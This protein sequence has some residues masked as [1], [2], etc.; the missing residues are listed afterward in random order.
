MIKV[1]IIDDHQLFIDG[2]IHSFKDDSDLKICGSALD[3]FSGMTMVKSNQPDVVIL[4]IDFS[5]T[6]ESGIDIMK[7]VKKFNP[8]IKVLI[9]TGHCDHGLINMLKKEGADGYRVKNIDVAELRQTILDVHLGHI[10]FKYETGMLKNEQIWQVQ[11]PNHVSDRAV[12]IIKLL[13][14]GF[15]VKE[16][17]QKLNIAE[18]TVN[19]HLERAKRKLNAKNNCELVSIAGKARLI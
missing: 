12:E 1:L 16:I 13:S 14:E 11:A 19:D 9:L 17:A 3:G 18:S 4:D 10:V 5:K 2:L 6:N 8:E 7:A 15:I